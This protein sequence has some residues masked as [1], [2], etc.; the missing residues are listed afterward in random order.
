[1]GNGRELSGKRLPE[2]SFPGAIL[3]KCS[4]RNARGLRVVT[5]LSV[6]IVAGAFRLPRL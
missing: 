6:L 5:A 1:M 3:V 4:E 2:Q